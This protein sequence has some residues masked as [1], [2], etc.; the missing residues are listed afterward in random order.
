MFPRLYWL[1]EVCGNDDLPG[2]KTMVEQFNN[3]TA[4]AAKF[5][6]EKWCTPFNSPREPGE[7]EF[8]KLHFARM[9]YDL[10][11][12]SPSFLNF[13]QG[14]DD[15]YTWTTG[16]GCG[17][18][19]G[20]ERF[21]YSGESDVDILG[22][23][24]RE[25]YNIDEGVA[26]G[27]MDRNFIIGGAEPAIGEYNFSSPLKTVKVVQTIYDTLVKEDIVK[28]VSNC[29]RPGGNLTISVEDAEE[30]LYLWK[31]AM[32]DTWSRDWDDEARGEVQFVGFYDG[33]GGVLGSTGRMM[34]EMT[35]DNT[36]LTFISIAVI[37]FFSVLLLFST[38]MV[39]SRTL[40]ALVGVG[41][42]V[43]SFFGA[44]GFSL[45][46]DT[47]INVTIAWTLPFIMVGLG[48]DDVY[49]ILMALKKQPGYSTQDW[50]NAMSE[51]LK[52]EHNFSTA[53]VPTSARFH[54]KA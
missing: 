25:V 34:E 48:V 10:L 45:L 21:A 22:N 26:I 43:L 12:V 11:V 7:G 18:K 46:V 52:D 47:K 51:P 49:I 3:S 36:K 15:P 9:F 1:I 32:E 24:S 40:I 38:D 20:G 28:R 29:H 42:V 8:T 30:I 35:L 23:A 33:D 39:E 5:V 16:A 17:Y 2:S 41:L 44:L 27:V 50:L 6:T 53:F 19:L 37:A 14:V 54:C 4:I 13:V 31:E